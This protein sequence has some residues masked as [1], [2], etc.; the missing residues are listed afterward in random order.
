MP[1]LIDLIVC[2]V[3]GAKFHQRW[4]LFVLGLVLLSSYN[5]LVLFFLFFVPGSDQSDGTGAAAQAAPVRIN[6]AEAKYQEQV[7]V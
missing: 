5:S 7:R 4:S 6:R 3:S 2:R 1:C